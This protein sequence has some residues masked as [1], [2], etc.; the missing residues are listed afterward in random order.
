[1]TETPTEPSSDPDVAP[2]E[3]EPGG[4]GAPEKQPDLPDPAFPEVLPGGDPG[5]GGV[6]E[7]E[8][9]HTQD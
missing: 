4:P 6:P 7:G 3:P 1:M 9:E 5:P 8:P 2:A